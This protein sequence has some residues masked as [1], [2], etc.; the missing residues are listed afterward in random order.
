MKKIEP[1]VRNLVIPTGSIPAGTFDLE[2][3]LIQAGT[4]S[5]YLCLSQIAS[6]VNRR[7]YRQGIDWAIGGIK[8]LSQ[9]GMNGSLT[10]SVMPSTW[11]AYRA[12]QKAF[13]AW[14]RQ[15]MEAVEESGAESAVARFRDFKVYLDTD[16][17]AAGFGANLLPADS[18][19]NFP[20][21]GEW[22]P[23]M[24][25]IPN[26]GAPGVNDERALHLVGANFNGS[27]SRGIIEGYADSRAYPQSPDPIHPPLDGTSNWLA[28]MFDVGDNTSEVLDNATDTNDD[29]PYSQVDYPGGE[30][31]MSATQ[32]FDIA[33]ISGTTIGGITRLKGGVVPCGLMRFDM[34]N[35]TNLSQNIVLQIDL[36]PGDHRGYMCQPTLEV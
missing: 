19:G 11:V 35:R 15:Q 34:T 17:V 13:S 22:E 4:L 14:N 8:V 29:L 3:N 5:Q 1:A 28:K 16:H 30:N 20:L 2:G 12:Y 9:A 36:V 26:S 7:F 24:I 10:A 18:A 33:Y 31:N 25:V 23:S 21:L 32:V 6:L 27:L